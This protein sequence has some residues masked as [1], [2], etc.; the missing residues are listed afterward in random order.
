LD[1]T[2]PARQNRSDEEILMIETTWVAGGLAEL[3][4]SILAELPSWFGIPEANADYATQAAANPGVIASIDGQHVGITTV[5]RHSPHAAEVHLMAV[6]PT[7]HRR[8][9]GKAMLHLAEQQLALEGVAFL[10]VKTLSPSR[11]DTGYAKTRAFYLAYGFRVLEDHPTLW[12]PVNPA[13]QLIKAVQ[14]RP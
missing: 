8:G 1:Q 13:L 7:Q 5:L 2:R 12:G 11:E 4:Q 6:R 10:Q 9:I 3:C 14:R